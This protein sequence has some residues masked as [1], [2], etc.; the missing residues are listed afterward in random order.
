MYR[1]SRLSVRRK[2]ENRNPGPTP[3]I[4]PTGRTLGWPIYIY[5][6]KSDFCQSMMTSYTVKRSYVKFNV[7][8]CQSRYVRSSIQGRREGGAGGDAD[9]GARR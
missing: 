4:S 1:Q 2:N 5:S 9:P 6:A 7:L 3:L 8:R